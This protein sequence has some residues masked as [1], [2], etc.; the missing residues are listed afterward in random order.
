MTD[1]IDP[2]SASGPVAVTGATGWVGREVCAWLEAQGRPVR[3]LSRSGAGP[4]GRRFELA[5]PRDERGEREALAGCAVVVH[6]AAHVHRPVETPAELEL[7]QRVN[8]EGTTR[9]LAA[10]RAVGV[11]RFV[12]ASTLAVYDW[13]VAGGPVSEG[14]PMR[15]A[16]AYARSKWE[17]ERAVQAAGGDWRIARL[18]TVYGIGDRANFSRLAA[19]LRRRRFVMPGDGRAQ[20]SVL[21][22][23][24]AAELLGRWAI[25]AGAGGLVMN[26]AAPVA[27][28]L[29]DICA[30]FTEVCGFSSPWRMPG[31]PLRMVARM[32]DSVALINPRLPRPSQVLAKLTT[33]T[34]VDVARMQSVFPLLPWGSFVETL[35]P[36]ASYYRSC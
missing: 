35:R 17:S 26:L 20:K 5:G 8:V 16:T 2:V 19:A 10:A 29:A 23:A 27:P 15:P 33:D 21:P 11:R 34:V 9:L 12:L 3:R 28:S 36:A 13:E 4:S 32:A 24:R 6:C 7:F 31:A 22:L 1:A 14:G 30:A 18:A 25:Q